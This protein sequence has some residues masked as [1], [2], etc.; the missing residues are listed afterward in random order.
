MKKKRPSAVF[1]S[2]FTQLRQGLPQGA[3]LTNKLRK[4]VIFSLLFTFRLLAV[5]FH[6][7]CFCDISHGAWK[8]G[9]KPL[10]FNSRLLNIF[11]WNSMFTSGI[12]LEHIFWSC[13]CTPKT[14]RKIPRVARWLSSAASNGGGGFRLTGALFGPRGPLCFWGKFFG[15][16][17]AQRS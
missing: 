15:P 11:Y 4:C 9:V 10:Q 2:T 1:G 13:W 8:C 16:P 12:Q 14:K 7:L 6:T 3:L 5:A 17:S